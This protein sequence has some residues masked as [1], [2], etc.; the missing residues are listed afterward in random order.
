VRL[1]ADHAI[2]RHYPDAARRAA[3]PGLLDAV[4]AAQA[5]SS[6]EW[7][8]VGFIHGVMNT[9][10]TSIAGETI[11]YGPCAFMDEFSSTTR[12]RSS[13][14]SIT[15]AAMPTATSRASAGGTWRGSPSALLPLEPGGWGQSQALMAKANPAVIPRNHRI[16]EAIAAAVAGDLGP[17]ERLARVLVAPFVEDPADNDLRLAPSEQEEVRRTF[18]GT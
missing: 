3:V 7:L 12:A 8:L 13:A 10:N 16:E 2:A 11:D 18:C 1:L 6:R 5:G 4:I 17:F 9:D 14:R 15:P